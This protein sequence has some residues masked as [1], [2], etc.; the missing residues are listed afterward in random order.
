MPSTVVVPPA[1]QRPHQHDVI[2]TELIQKY[3]DENQNLILAIL[4]NQNVGKLNECV[5]YQQ[6]WGGGA[7]L[8][9]GLKARLLSKVQPD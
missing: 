2:T 8:D 4:E 5:L 9:P 1:Q 7:K 6:R 3:L